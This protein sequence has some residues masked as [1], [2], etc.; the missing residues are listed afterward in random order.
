M[1]LYDKIYCNSVYY[2]LYFTYIFCERTDIMMLVTDI[3]ATGNTS[4]GVY[5]IIFIAA[6][7]IIA[8]AVIIGIISKKKK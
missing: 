3:P 2:V 8:A 1:H 6:V 7:V 5:L 4:A